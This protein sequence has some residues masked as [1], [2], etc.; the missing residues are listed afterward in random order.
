MTR[1]APDA[2]RNVDTVVE[3]GVVRQVV[4]SGPLDGLTFL[5]TCS[6]QFEVWTVGPDLRVAVHTGFGRGHPG[7]RRD[8]DG[9]V[10]VTAVNP[11]VA[12]VVLVAELNG[13][14]TLDVLPRVVRRTVNLGDNPDHREED[15]DRSENTQLRERI[16]AVMENLRH[17]RT[18]WF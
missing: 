1:R 18:L 4:H 15:K 6:H 14:L 3:I 12:R 5:P 17:S 10:A 2:F 9:R 11:V 8:F 7:A 16:S 13:L